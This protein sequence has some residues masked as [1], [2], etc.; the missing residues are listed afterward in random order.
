MKT[1]AITTL[2]CK[3]N[4]V[5]SDRYIQVMKQANMQ[6]V[7]F[8]ESA[9]TYIINT[10]AVTHAAAAKSRQ[11]I[12]QAI[13]ANP[14]AKIVVV[15]CSLAGDM[16]NLSKIKEIDTL[17]FQDQKDR[18][19][20]IVLK[21]TFMKELHVV[22]NSKTRGFLKIQDGCEQFCSFCIIPIA[23]GAE[24]SVI[25]DEL[26]ETTRQLVQANHKEIVLT[27]I[28]IGKYGIKDN[29]SLLELLTRLVKI[30][31]LKRLR[32]SSIEITELHDELI[33]FIAHQPIIAKHLHIPLQS[34]S[35]DVLKAMNR[36]YDMEYFFDRVALIRKKIPNVLI[37]SDVIAGFVNESE[38]QFQETVENIKKLKLGFL[39]V[40]PYSKRKFTKAALMNGHLSSTIIKERSKMLNELSKDLRKQFHQDY[41]N[42][43]VNVLTEHPV[44]QG[45]FGHSEHY[46]PVVVL[47]H[48]IHR[49][50]VVRVRINNVT[51]NM[52][53]GII[54]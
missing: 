10:C 9:D 52:C 37:S 2:G 7:D 8:K 17:V 50:E 48:S 53:F 29:T 11:R 30:E 20:E 26:E 18:F 46:L 34:G 3:V 22:H 15:G 28:H 35:N 33:D 36:P 41:L 44:E 5:E 19:D 25:I 54:E 1:F 6:Q 43:V 45:M 38:A 40:F 27:G 31:G 23:R 12:A 51:S 32:L 39:H 13:K 4:S 42:K 24:K 16:D 14:D 47:D 49:N 21:Q